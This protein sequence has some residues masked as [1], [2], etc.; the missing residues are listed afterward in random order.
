MKTGEQIWRQALLL[1]NYVDAYGAVDAARDVE[2]CRR[3]LA[4][5]NR[6][7]G[8][9]WYQEQGEKPFVPL[10]RITDT[11]ALSERVRRTVM[12]Y[13]VAM[14]LA[15]S[16]SDGDQQMLFATLYNAKRTAVSRV[17]CRLDVLP[18]GSDS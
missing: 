5:V 18:R 10:D 17:D 2:L 16:E 12:P 7:Y 4:A 6:I 8:E 14:L 1:L 13:G 3:G 9:L 15:Q 11:V